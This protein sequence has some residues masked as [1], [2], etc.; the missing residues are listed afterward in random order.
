M[1]QAWRWMTDQMKKA[2]DFNHSRP[3]ILRT[4]ENQHIQVT[5]KVDNVN[6][7]LYVNK[8]QGFLGSMNFHKMW[9]TC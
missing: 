6:I 5:K 9:I 3:F 7:I 4:T 8:L 1:T 2:T